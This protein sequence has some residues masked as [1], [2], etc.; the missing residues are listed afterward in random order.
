VQHIYEHAGVLLRVDYQ[1]D[2]SGEHTF[3]SV[4][5]LDERYRPVGPD[6][7]PLLNDVL[8]T[9]SPASADGGLADCT[10]FLSAICEELQ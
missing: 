8:L 7:K 4:R 10:T 6:L 2:Q 5:V 3:N 1:T 9:L